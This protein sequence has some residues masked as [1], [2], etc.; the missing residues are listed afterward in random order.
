MRAVSGDHLQRDA[1]CRE[2]GERFR[3]V[4]PEPLGQDD[5]RCR[6]Q[7]GRKRVSPERAFGMRQHQ[8]AVAARGQLGRPRQ[9]VVLLAGQHHLRRTK[10]P[11]AMS[12]EAGRAPLACRREG[13]GRRALPPARRREGLPDRTQRRVAV[14][15]GG[16]RPEGLRHRGL[17]AEPDQAVE[18]DGPVGQGAG[19]VDA[20]HVHPGQALDGGQLLH[21]DVA[22]GQGDRGHAEGDTGQQHQ[23]LRD[24]AHQRRDRPGERLP[25]RVPGM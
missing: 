18:R 17:P 2:V 25:Y 20:Q 22:P 21:Q 16:E 1:L 6:P 8:D 7:A 12:G 19:L 23:P 9:L 13:H 15:V 14:L 4:G 5:E 24:H 10:D 3:R 11:G